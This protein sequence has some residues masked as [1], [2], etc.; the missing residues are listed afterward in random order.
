M[1]PH[2]D[3]VAK[4]GES[5]VNGVV[6][7]LVYQMVQTTRAGR[8]DVH[9]WTLANSFKAFEDLNVRTVVVLGFILSH[10]LLL[11]VCLLWSDGITRQP[12][13]NSISRYRTGYIHVVYR[14]SRLI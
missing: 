14:L 10:V 6:D 5:L 9:A 8:T 4:T 7:D 11:F 2:L 12:A 1:D 13:N 3:T